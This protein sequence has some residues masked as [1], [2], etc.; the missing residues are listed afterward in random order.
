MRGHFLLSIVQTTHL[1]SFFLKQFF[2]SFKIRK[3]WNYEKNF[4]I[5][6]IVGCIFIGY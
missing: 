6:I 5:R 2:Y 4:I 1:N 3:G